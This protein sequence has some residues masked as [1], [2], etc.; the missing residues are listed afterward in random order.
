MRFWIVERLLFCRTC[1]ADFLVDWKVACGASLTGADDWAE[2]VLAADL[3][4]PRG[5]D[6]SFS[7]NEQSQSWIC[8]E[9]MRS[10]WPSVL[11]ALQK[12]TPLKRQNL[13]ISYCAPPAVA[14]RDAR[15]WNACAFHQVSLDP[16]CITWKWPQMEW[17][18]TQNLEK[19]NKLTSG[20]DQ[21]PAPLQTSAHP[22]CHRSVLRCVSH[23]SKSWPPEGNFGMLQG[24][25]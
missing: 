10:E 1:F 15:N 3:V 7:V 2:S 13:S 21:Q 25:L 4:S 6:D 5:R 23:H 22:G 24:G 14:N 18:L 20:P 17:Q 19:V 8:D 9:A 11:W 12:F 16:K